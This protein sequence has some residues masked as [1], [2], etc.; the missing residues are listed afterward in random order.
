MSN[1]NR[2]IYN[3]DIKIK[4]KGSILSYPE[5]LNIKIENNKD[6]I[7]N[8][9]LIIQIEINNLFSDNVLS[10][11]YGSFSKWN[12][13]KDIEDNWEFVLGSHSFPKFELIRIKVTIKGLDEEIG[14]YKKKTT[15][16]FVRKGLIC[17]IPKF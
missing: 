9:K 8:V 2:M 4:L 14:L 13:T 7:S 15:V 11:P 6:T 5:Q 3:E 16:G 17:I 1:L 12:Y 10:G